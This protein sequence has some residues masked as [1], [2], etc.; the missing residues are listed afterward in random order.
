[1]KGDKLDNEIRFKGV[2]REDFIP[3]NIEV[4]K[5]LNDIQKVGLKFDK[6]CLAL[7]CP[8]CGSSFII[9]NI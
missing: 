7:E 3:A 2:K 5:Y 6:K 8:K 9:D 4:D 1:M